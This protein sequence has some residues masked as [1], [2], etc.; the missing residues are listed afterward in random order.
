M[1]V[2]KDTK[3][4]IKAIHKVISSNPKDV[5]VSHTIPETQYLSVRLENEDGTAYEVFLDPHPIAMA[6]Y[7]KSVKRADMKEINNQALIGEIEIS[8][9]W[10]GGAA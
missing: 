6:Y 10:M 8:H 2:T 9:E 4:I 1:K 7:L 5:V 3:I